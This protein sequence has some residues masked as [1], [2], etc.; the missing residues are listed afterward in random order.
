[1]KSL[2]IKALFSLFE[3]QTLLGYAQ[4]RDFSNIV[5]KSKESCQNAGENTACHFVDV[6]KTMPMPK[7]ADRD[8]E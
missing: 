6:S 3:Q 7:G 1:M 8:D 5:D 4:W 2:E